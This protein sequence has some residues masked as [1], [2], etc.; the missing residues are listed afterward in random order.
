MWLST[1][2]AVVSMVMRYIRLDRVYRIQ[3]HAMFLRSQDISLF[4]HL[5]P[6]FTL[7]D[8]KFGGYTP[9]SRYWQKAFFQCPI[10]LASLQQTEKNALWNTKNK[11]R[12]KYQ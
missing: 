10:L 5:K 8:F 12:K 6:P 4:S 9:I 7:H 3:S 2:N 11:L 1:H